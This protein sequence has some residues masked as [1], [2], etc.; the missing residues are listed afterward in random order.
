MGEN[1]VL[2]IAIISYIAFIAWC[3]YRAGPSNEAEAFSKM[4]RDV[5][6]K[7]REMLRRNELDG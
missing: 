1:E 5:G 2:E 6:G 7:Y 4:C 3:R